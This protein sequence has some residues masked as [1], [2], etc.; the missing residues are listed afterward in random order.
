M[1]MKGAKHLL[2]PKK[3]IAVFT[4]VMTKFHQVPDGSC[5]VFHNAVDPAVITQPP[6]ALGSEMVAVYADAAPPRCCES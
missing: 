1:N 6:V 5:V 2:T 3:T 4:P